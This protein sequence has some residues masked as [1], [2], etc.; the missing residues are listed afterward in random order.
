MLRILVLDLLAVALLAAAYAVHPAV[1]AL[2]G[3]VVGFPMAAVT[4]VS[5][6]A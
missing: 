5:I 6:R 4:A 3:M 2:V 1:A